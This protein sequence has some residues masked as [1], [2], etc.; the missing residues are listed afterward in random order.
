VITERTIVRLEPARWRERARRWQRVAREAAKQC[1][2]V[3]VPEVEIPRSL[4]E[5]LAAMDA[6]DLLVCLW[7]G[8]SAPLAT[9]FDGLAAPPERLHVLVGPEGGLA[10]DEVD[11]ARAHGFAVVGLGP[12][13]LRTETVAPAF[14]AIVQ[15][16]LGDL[17]SRT[18]TTH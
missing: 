5:C 15:A 1:G 16:R 2:R 14:V 3:M 9:L 10:R 13:T 11:A 4:A 7:E 8:A 6:S 18:V 12:R 17:T